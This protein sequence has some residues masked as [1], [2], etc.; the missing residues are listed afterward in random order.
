M[1]K[2]KFTKL[3]T[4]D[5][6]NLLGGNRSKKDCDAMIDLWSRDL[7]IDDATLVDL[8]DSFNKSGCSQWY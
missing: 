4:F 5:M 6:K 2:I 7:D 3:S 8:M 1:E